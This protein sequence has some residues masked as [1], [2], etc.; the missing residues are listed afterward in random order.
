MAYGIVISNT[1]GT[2]IINTT[3]R[4]YHEVASGTYTNESGL[5][6]PKQ[7]SDMVLVRPSGG[8]GILR[9]VPMPTET[10]DG[11][12][13][14]AMSS[15]GSVEWAVL[16]ESPAAGGGTY[17]L[18]VFSSTNTVL[19]DFSRRVANPVAVHTA[20]LN[21]TDFNYPTV[22]NI[23]LPDLTLAS[24]KRYVSSTTFP[25]S[26]YAAPSSP[27]SFGFEYF[28]P[29]VTFNSNTSISVTEVITWSTNGAQN[30]DPEHRWSY[31]IDRYRTIATLSFIDL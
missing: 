25:L 5:I 7:P 23:T 19:F 9:G 29:K 10:T 28:N 24:R 4:N 11:M 3:Y 18:R 21:Y 14:P 13:L 2:E 22:T 17:G 31:P 20:P 1:S 26:A 12:Y 16:R 6:I 27:M 30:A 8:V 15:T